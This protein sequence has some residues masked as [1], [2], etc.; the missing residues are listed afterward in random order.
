[1]SDIKAKRHSGPGWSQR[2]PAS[3]LGRRDALRSALWAVGL[4][5]TIVFAVP[6]IA[7]AAAPPREAVTEFIRTTADRMIGIINGNEDFATKRSQLQ[8]VVDDAVD[9]QQIAR[10]CLGRYWRVAKP[11]QRQRFIQLFHR[12]LLDG[13]TGQI[14][15][16]RGVRI[17][18]GRVTMQG[19]TTTVRSTVTRPG[20]AAVDAEWVV[21]ETA[22][23]L[24]IQDIVAEGVSMRLTRRTDYRSYLRRHGGKIESLLAAMH[25]QLARS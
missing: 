7:S 4:S 13:V 10:F 15:G 24:R 12:V 11:A 23:G 5:P 17:D 20:Q 9:I 14:S 21:A 6:E 19:E 16:Y 2:A 25:N 3:T 22:T 8:T 1:M 18:L